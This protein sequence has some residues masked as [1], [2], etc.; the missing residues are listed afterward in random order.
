[1]P[2]AVNVAAALALAA[3]SIIILASAFHLAASRAQAWRRR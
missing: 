3:A 2:G 1:M